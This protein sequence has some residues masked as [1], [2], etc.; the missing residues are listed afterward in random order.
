LKTFPTS[1]NDGWIKATELIAPYAGVDQNMEGSKSRAHFPG[2]F[3][4]QQAFQSRV[5]LYRRIEHGSERP[6]PGIIKAK[7]HLVDQVALLWKSPQTD[8]SV[9][10]GNLQMSTHQIHEC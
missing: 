3:D 10:H 8:G 9:T 2:S 5:G 1:L 4:C 6:E 7:E